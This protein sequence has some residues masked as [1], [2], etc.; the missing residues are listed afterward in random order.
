MI[1][2]RGPQQKDSRAYQ[3]GPLRNRGCLRLPEATEASD[4]GKSWDTD[5]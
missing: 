1:P 2:A 4:N 5:L 3:P